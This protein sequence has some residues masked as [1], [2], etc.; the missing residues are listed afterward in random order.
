MSDTNQ[1]ATYA[2]PDTAPTGADCT[3]CSPAW[4]TRP[5]EEPRR[6]RGLVGEI[7]ALKRTRN[8]VILAH[9]YQRPEIFQVADFV[10]DSLEL[11]REATKVDAEVIVSAALFHGGDRQDPE[12]EPTVI[13]PDLR[14]GC[15]SPTAS[16]PRTSPTARRSCDACIRTA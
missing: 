9:N 12:P 5:T 13:L 4:A 6:D 1:G 3:D 14:A 2:R 11:A 15:C 7:E 16:P 10:G 8:A